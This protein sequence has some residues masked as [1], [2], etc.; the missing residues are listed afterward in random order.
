MPILVDR[1]T[2]KIS[3]SLSFFIQ[4]SENLR[5]I[6]TTNLFSHSIHRSAIAIPT[7]C[8]SNYIAIIRKYN[9]PRYLKQFKIIYIY[10]SRGSTAS[11]GPGH[12]HC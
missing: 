6:Y 2:L 4:Y 5:F 9:T 7:V 10:F 8:Y 1:E 11:S 3:V 12:P